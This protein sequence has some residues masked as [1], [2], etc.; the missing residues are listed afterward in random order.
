MSIDYSLIGKRIAKVRKS[1]GYT[2]DNLAE[3]ANLSNN[4]ISHIEKSHSIPSLE[5]FVNLCEALEVTPDE[6]L[7]GSVKESETYLNS[8]IDN[9]LSGCSPYEKEMI[10]GFIDL[11]L[12]KRDKA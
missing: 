12:S 6:I 4:Y 8:E 10:D 2:Q 7:L 5:T 11:L 1:R 3:R 9:K